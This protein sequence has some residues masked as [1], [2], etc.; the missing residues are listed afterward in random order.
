MK[1]FEK[2]DKVFLINLKKRADRLDFF[3]EQ[4]KKFN[5]GEFEIFE[6]IDTT[7]KTMQELNIHY[8]PGAYGLIQSNIEILKIA[9][10]KNYESIC[11]IEDDCVFKDN[12]TDVE[13]YFNFLPSDWDLLYFGGN[14]NYNSGVPEPIEINEHIIKL[15]HSYTTHFVCIKKHMYEKLISDFSSFSQ[16]LDLMYIKFQRENNVYS[17]KPGITTQLPG[18][19]DILGYNA[20]YLNAIN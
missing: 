16:P 5:L 18:F 1:L 7:K 15:Y 20:N 2:F 14:H 13:K 4:V 12:I 19:S 10:E 3:K 17:F 6:A 8:P 11:I 9:L